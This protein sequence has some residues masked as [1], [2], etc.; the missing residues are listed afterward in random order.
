MTT[1]I[2][3]PSNSG[4]FALYIF[5]YNALEE[6]INPTSKS[7]IKNK[8]EIPDDLNNKEISD[9]YIVKDAIYQDDNMD[10]IKKKI[11]YYLQEDNVKPYDIYTYGLVEKTLYIK[12]IF[13]VL[14]DTT[15]D[16]I[17]Y[18]HLFYYLSNILDSDYSNLN[19][20][21]TRSE[22]FNYSSLMKMNLDEK[23]VF[24]FVP[25]SLHK[26][27]PFYIS[28]LISI[29]KDEIGFS[30]YIPTLTEKG[31]WK[32]TI[33]T[34]NYELLLHYG[35]KNNC[36]Y[37]NTKNDFKKIYENSEYLNRF[38]NVYFPLSSSIDV[39]DS[40]LEKEKYIHKL[41]HIE[42]N[43]MEKTNEGVFTFHSIIEPMNDY[44]IPVNVFFKT[45]HA[46]NIYPFVKLNAAKNREK[47]YKLHTHEYSKNGNK[48]PSM[49]R[50]S[51]QKWNKMSNKKST[52]IYIDIEEIDLF[53]C[54]FYENGSIRVYIE[55]S[56]YISLDECSE[57]IQQYVNPLI[58]DMNDYISSYGY[59]I[60]PYQSM[61]QLSLL[62]MDYKLL[63]YFP[64]T[65][66]SFSSVMKC[67]SPFFV[68]SKKH[69]KDEYT[70][71]YKRV[72]HF[73]DMESID[74][75][76]I[77]MLNQKKTRTEIESGLSSNYGK[78]ID[79]AKTIYNNTIDKYKN[80]IQLNS[81]QVL[82]VTTN[83][84]FK[85]QFLKVKSQ[86]EIIIH[87]I[88]ELAIL[89]HV[90]NHIELA[91]FL[92][93][94]RKIT[95]FCGK[96]IK[97]KEEKKV[98][99][100]N[101]YV[102]EIKDKDDD[103]FMKDILSDDDEDTS[104]EEDSSSE[105]EDKSDDDEDDDEEE[106]E[107]NRKS[108]KV[109]ESIVGGALSDE[110]DDEDD[111][112]GDDDV[113]DLDAL[114]E[115][116]EDDEDILDL[117]ALVESDEG[118]GDKDDEGDEDDGDEGDEDE[119]EG[120]KEEQKIES[121][122][123][124][125]SIKSDKD[126]NESPIPHPAS[127]EEPKEE[128]NDKEEDVDEDVDEN[129]M[130]NDK[131]DDV[132]ENE[133]ES[134]KEED[135]MVDNYIY[136]K[137]NIF[138]EKLKK[139]EPEIFID[140]VDDKKKYEVYSRMCQW[141]QRRTPVLLT[142]E[143]KEKI[144]N[145]YEGKTKPYNYALEYGSN[146]DKKYYY[147][148]PRYWCLKTN[149]PITEEERLAG[150]C[151]GSDKIIPYNTKKT[152][153]DAFILEFKPNNKEYKEQGPGFLNP[154]KHE[155]GY[156]AACC[157]PG[158]KGKNFKEKK[159]DICMDNDKSDKSVTKSETLQKGNYI[160]GIEKFPLEQKRLGYI[161]PNIQEFLQLGT[162]NIIFRYGVENN[163]NQSFVGVLAD[164]YS[165]Y[166]DNKVLSINDMKM[167][168]I[169]SI[170][171]EDYKHYFN[172]S[173]YTLFL[174]KDMQYESMDSK[175]EFSFKHFQDFILDPKSS[176]DYTYLWDIVSKPHAKLFPKGLNLV[177]IEIM[178]KDMT[179]NV[180]LVCPTN[181][182]SNETFST[183]KPIVFIM[184]KDKYF[185][186]LY[187]N[188]KTKKEIKTMKMFQ[189]KDGKKMKLH[190]LFETIRQMLD[191][192]SPI[193]Y[194]KIETKTPIALQELMNK[195]EQ[196]PEMEIQY[197]I[198][199]PNNKII[200]LLVSYKDT[201]IYIPC[202]PTVEIDNI[203]ILDM[204]A[205]D[206]NDLPNYKDT[207]MYLNDLYIKHNL[208]LN[209]I[210]KISNDGVIVGII[211]ETNQFIPV[212]IDDNEVPIDDGVDIIEGSNY[213][214]TRSIYI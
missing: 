138:L 134:D 112:E 61:K 17:K 120:D 93:R 29:L 113:L 67:L 37:V 50:S 62:A 153:P 9:V 65:L 213:F 84:G 144:D 100:V 72:G 127:I 150:K 175:L 207:V 15:F 18:R 41:K 111:D 195:I 58:H 130:E 204:N 185:E 156:C 110:D 46:D 202:A 96:S 14:K 1:F 133:M 10:T 103:D 99:N 173:L 171:I 159:I 190:N 75:Y 109:K 206:V 49:S 168:L 128:E 205:I 187:A 26:L 92:L 30:A 214:R 114:V 174:P 8:Y 27:Q 70:L 31:N 52:F 74:A 162:N 143:E 212:K 165:V 115:S 87:N 140:R 102:F 101:K 198:I 106:K 77:E 166:N 123:H 25:L 142:K 4:T 63:Y 211:V 169:E 126:D 181:I 194:R 203:P 119:K 189:Y 167:K 107:D 55:N 197:Q 16:H 73:D 176:I 199:H 132:D 129:E 60:Q 51:F 172:G 160:K 36:I 5:D 28:N 154:I 24:E 7:I 59:F 180:G 118:D 68:V 35:L 94:Q 170:T 54:D 85:I 39:E 48:I 34:E 89:P 157:F 209:V 148:C 38:M 43:D 2:V 186:P 81:N 40:F 21:L 20:I 13:N 191:K 151:G 139:Y 64:K 42:L 147:I 78:T 200:A 90:I 104:E 196:H 79:E 141:N 71:K 152:P 193:P 56:N 23:K 32:D 178:E 91:I 108:I 145:E 137:Q 57:Y 163:I 146:P 182:Y 6:G 131:E 33:Q 45:I 117:D 125:A 53:Y 11:A 69:S 184:K 192:C 122:I 177:I 19:S 183:N 124:P 12:E 66:A 155:K 22:F 121:V 44:I 161:P 164:L 201:Y 105:E 179:N 86:L 88:N 3:H 116:D 136:K 208:P 210:K 80:D 76:I 82:R 97:V 149:K 47:T 83:P 95:P 158:F 188:I 135:D 98:E